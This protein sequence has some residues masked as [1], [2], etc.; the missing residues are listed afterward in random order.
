M[1]TGASPGS[2]GHA[3][4]LYQVHYPSRWMSIP[5]LMQLVADGVDDG[6][7]RAVGV[8]NHSANQMRLAWRGVPRAQEVRPAAAYSPWIWR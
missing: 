3:S 1:V 7:I 8:G 6:R 5:T 2:D 4:N